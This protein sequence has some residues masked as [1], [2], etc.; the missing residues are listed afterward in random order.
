MAPKQD[1]LKIISVVGARPQFMKAR[2]LS[3]AIKKHNKTSRTPQVEECIVHTG[4]HYDA[5]MSQVFFDQLRI[6]APRYNLGVG[7]GSHAE[8]TAQMLIGIEGILLKERPDWVIVFGDTNT[9]LAGSFAGAKIPVPVVHVEAGLRSFNR[10]MPEEINRVLTDHLSRLLFCPSDAAVL[11]LE[12]EGVRDGVFKVGDVLYDAFRIS[13]KAALN[14]SRVLTRL[15]VKPKGYCLATVHRQENTDD[16]RNLRRIF[17]AFER[18]AER[19]CPLV[20]PLHPRTREAIRNLKNFKLHNP[21]IR[22]IPPQGYLD[23]ICLEINARAILTDS[24]GVQREAFFARVPCLTLREETEWVETLATG[25][26]RL[27][28]TDPDKIAEAYQGILE[29]RLQR[30]PDL[31][32]DG[33][34]GERIVRAIVRET[35]YDPMAWRTRDKP[36]AKAVGR[37]TNG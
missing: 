23:T 17:R 24:G 10:R 26:N 3:R 31:Y 5:A 11:N 32:G 19:N 22:L 36:G 6:P 8:M 14:G 35:P 37:E 25:W 15:G 28:G 16:K 21:F 33:R 9:T 1:R 18:I 7:A 2:M 34:A 27:T 20:I 29:A 12:K 13:R 4:Q 30:A